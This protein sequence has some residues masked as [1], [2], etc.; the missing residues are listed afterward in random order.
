MAPVAGYMVGCADS[1]LDQR[2]VTRKG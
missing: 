1:S 2:S